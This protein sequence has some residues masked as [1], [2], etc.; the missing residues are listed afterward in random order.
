MHKIGDAMPEPTKFT[1][2]DTVTFNRVHSDYCPADGWALAYTLAGQGGIIKQRQGVPVDDG[3]DFEFTADDTAGLARGSYRLVGRVTRGT[4]AH[5]IYNGEL[6][7]LQNIFAA[8]TAVDTRHRLEKRLEA[9]NAVID[10]RAST[11]QQYLAIGGR[12]LQRMPYAE[13]KELRNDTRLELKAVRN[14]EGMARGLP[15]QNLIKARFI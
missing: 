10:G 4:Q 11:D 7:V 14:R 1:A 15:N 13:L 8:E 5:T 3:F 2:G 9:I 6:E 12:T